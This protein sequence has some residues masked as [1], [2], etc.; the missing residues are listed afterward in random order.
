MSELQDILGQIPV[1]QLVDMLGTHRQTAQTAVEAAAASLGD[2]RGGGQELGGMGA[3][4]SGS[5]HCLELFAV[6]A[7]PVVYGRTSGN[8]I[9]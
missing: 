6:S 4:R 7:S 8:A 1:D 3:G 9:L 5:P 2:L